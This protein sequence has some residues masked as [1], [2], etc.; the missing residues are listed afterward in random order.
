MQFERIQ[1]DAPLSSGICSLGLGLHFL[2]SSS[3]DSLLVHASTVGPQVRIMKLTEV[4]RMF[5]QQL[6]L[7]MY[8]VD[9][10]LPIAIFFGDPSPG[11]SNLELTYG[12]TSLLIAQEK[13]VLLWTDTAP[14]RLAIGPL[15][16]W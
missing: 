11:E 2:A 14:K 10:G 16:H 5:L 15:C 12:K 6:S 4:S 9:P 1:F 7:V 8:K 3:G 13:L